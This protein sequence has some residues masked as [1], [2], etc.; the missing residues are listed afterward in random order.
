MSI[1]YSPARLSLF[2]IAMLFIS[3]PAYAA[4]EAQEGGKTAQIRLAFRNLNEGQPVR[5]FTMKDTGGNDVALSA[6]SGKLVVAVF[7]RPDQEASQKALSD[8]QKLYDKYSGKGVVFLAITPELEQEQKI[9]DLVEKEHIKFPVLL[10]AGRKVYGDW[11]VFLY[12]TTGILDKETKLYK[13]VASYNRQYGETVEAYIRLL[14]GE[15]N[16]EQLDAILNPKEMTE[17]TPEQKKAQR[18][19]NLAGRMIERKL[20]DKAAAEYEQAIESDPKLVEAHVKYGFLLLKMGNGQKAMENFK[21]AIELDP[22]APDAEAGLGSAH[23]A[24]GEVDKGIEVLEGALKM[25]PKPARTHYELGLA[26]EKKG[27][28]DK[29]AE[30]YR[31]AID[32]LGGSDW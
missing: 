17:L 20:L 7:F 26:Y 12:P 6:Y 19:M 14:L 10:D 32:E 3:L 25:N 15:I 21:K 30:N 8:L 13:H 23:V 31:K 27:A 24:L 2:L 22:K 18:H 1:F 28:F 29:A 4:D 5:G 16:K 9:R 11:G